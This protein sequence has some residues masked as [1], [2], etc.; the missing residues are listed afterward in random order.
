MHAGCAGVSL[1]VCV[2]IG[3]GLLA[4]PMSPRTLHAAAAYG[5][6]GLVGFLGQTVVAMQA[7]LVPMV[8]WFWRYSARGYRV[9][10]PSP[11]AMRDR[12]LQAIVFAGWLIAV[13]AMAAGLFLESARLVGVGG[14][15]LFAAVSI[16]TLDNVL[17]ITP[18]IY[19]PKVRE[20]C[21]STPANVSAAA[22]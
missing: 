19:V 16:A 17:V 9:P 7:R 15:S 6:L 3:L 22:R 1:V 18:A 5:I 10:P 20:R 12:A 11:H 2:A 21:S 14:W 8:A 13:P 4:L